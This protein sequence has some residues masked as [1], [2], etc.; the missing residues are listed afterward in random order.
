[1]SAM[2]E[3]AASSGAAGY[4]IRTATP[5]DLAVVMHHRRRMFED[6]GSRDPEGLARMAATSEPLIERG[7]RDGSYRGWLVVHPPDGV[8]AG[9]GLIGLEYHSSPRDFAS[10]RHWIVNVY[11]EPA[12]RRKQ[13]ARWICETIVAWCREAGLTSVNLHA[14]D[15]GRSLY[16]SLGF[17]P[18]NEMRLTLR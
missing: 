1:M 8:I 4:S 5:D 7:L 14:S 6:M 15:E 3:R 10:R 11:T 16:E 18:T 12:H 9:G 17:T 13:L 2:S